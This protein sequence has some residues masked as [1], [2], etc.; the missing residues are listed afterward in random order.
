LY[1]TQ[2]KI[3]STGLYTRVYVNYL[4]N[5]DIANLLMQHTVKE[6]YKMY[7]NDSFDFTD[8]Y[9]A[10]QQNIFFKIYDI[11]IL[12][13]HYKLFQSM[14][15][16]LIFIVVFIGSILYL[17]LKNIRSRTAFILLIICAILLALS[18][19]HSMFFVYFRYTYSSMYVYFVTLGLFPF[20]IRQAFCLIMKKTS[21]QT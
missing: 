19:I 4:K 13:I 6:F 20:W 1:H 12:K 15:A 8:R 5:P 2:E 3:Y 9:S 7:D 17:L 16:L 10:M 11:Y 14:P 18:V 21:K